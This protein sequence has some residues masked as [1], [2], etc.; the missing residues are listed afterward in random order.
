MAN[1]ASGPG[2]YLPRFVVV[3]C[4]RYFKV[5]SK[6]LISIACRVVSHRLDERELDFIVSVSRRSPVPIGGLDQ[7]VVAVILKLRQV[8][9]GIHLRKQ[10]ARQI[11][12]NGHVPIGIRAR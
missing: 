11:K 5:H 1:R 3:S 9:Q 12:T 6:T 7:P 2:Q 10:V 8:P 4:V